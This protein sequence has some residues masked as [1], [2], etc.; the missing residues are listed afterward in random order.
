MGYY[1]VPTGFFPL[2]DFGVLSFSRSLDLS[3]DSLSVSDSFS[4]SR[5]SISSET[6]SSDS[7]SV[8]S[9]KS[10]SSFMSSSSE[11]ISTPLNTDN[12]EGQPLLLFS[13]WPFDRQPSLRYRI[14]ILN[15]TAEMTPNQSHRTPR[16]NVGKKEG[17]AHQR[18]GGSLVGY[19]PVGSCW[20]S[21]NGVDE[22]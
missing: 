16:M 10:R 3:S 9:S 22:G 4:S 12:A 21:S 18:E 14:V 5:S 1:L 6:C 15:A 20:N 19:E 8:S 13:L 11:L 7:S 2:C 17:E